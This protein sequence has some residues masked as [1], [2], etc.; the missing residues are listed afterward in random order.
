MTETELRSRLL[1]ES[2][3]GEAEAGERTWEVIRAAYATRERVPWIERHPRAVLVV[4]VVAALTV[5]GVTPPGQALLQRVRDKVVGVTPSEP[6]LVRLPASG[7]LLVESAQGPW[8]VRAD[9]SKRRLGA[10]E[11]ASWSPRGVFVVATRGRQVVALE[12]DGDVRWTL[13]RPGRVTDTRWAPSGFRIAYREGETLRV[14]VGNGENDHLL[15]RP[16]AAVAPAWRP[17]S[18][19]NVLAYGDPDGRIHVVDVD[20]REELWST[21]SGPAPTQLLWSSDGERLLALSS[22]ERERIY[23]GRGRLAETLELQPG[24]I[25]VDAAF[26]PTGGALA[27]TDFDVASGRAALVV[28]DRGSSRTLFPASAG[29][30]EDVAWSPNGRWLLV[31]W[32]AADQ[33]L[34]LRTPGVRGLV[35]VSHVAREF[36]P[37]GTGTHAFPRIAGWVEDPTG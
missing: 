27:Y 34:F 20:T 19:Q 5:A 3:S 37:G 32:P 12:P 17:G 13:T 29:R 15:V 14:V 22:G 26:A 4:A 2:L 9:G 21:P 25:A 8:V 28:V 35:S 16:V 31:T 33:W 1:G 10:Y 11:H 7:R 36:D 18:T 24:H 6:A 23:N 30:L